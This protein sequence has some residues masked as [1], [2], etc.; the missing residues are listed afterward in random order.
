LVIQPDT[1]PRPANRSPLLWVI[2]LLIGAGAL[3][4]LARPVPTPVT[5]PAEVLQRLE[6]LETSRQVAETQLARLE[7]AVTRIRL[8]APLP[9]VGQ[10]T[11][12]GTAD[13]LGRLAA[14][15]G[16]QQL[17]LGAMQLQQ[18]MRTSRP[19]QNELELLQDI[20][21][22]GAL[23]EILHPLAPPAATGVATVAEL[24]D[25]FGVILLP[26]LQTLEQDPNRSWLEA[27]SHWWNTTLGWG[28][29]AA[30][31]SAA[32]LLLAA[33]L[34]RLSENNLQGAV[35]VLKQLQGSQA[36]LTARWLVEA[37]TRLAVD[38]AAV[39]LNGAVIRILGRG[40]QAPR[41]LN[42]AAEAAKP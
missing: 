8:P 35:A 4:W 42:A 5:V 27:I 3:Y 19:F 2:V 1:V 32:Q 38:A 22:G 7:Q 9:A 29:S 30:A 34:D 25:A 24:R 23:A 20:D 6:T 10:D 41:P 39:A 17:A 21:G 13:A 28:D 15:L 40:L 14:L 16:D 26:K 12:A 37:E 11:G 33:A 36:R 18:A 31:A